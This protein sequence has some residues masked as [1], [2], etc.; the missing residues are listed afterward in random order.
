VGSGPSDDNWTFN[1]RQDPDV[2]A[3]DFIARAVRPQADSVGQPPPA[4]V[5]QT[6]GLVDK[7]PAIT[8]A[9]AGKVCS[10]RISLGLT[11][12]IAGVCDP[13][14][15]GMHPLR[16]VHGHIVSEGRL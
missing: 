3:P 8:L 14:N 1:P 2:T 12:P 4:G 6:G 16:V 11:S 10:V 9:H 5:S 13:T 15:I 7:V